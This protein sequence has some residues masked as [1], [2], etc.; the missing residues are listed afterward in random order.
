MAIF[1][2][3]HP[4]L[5][6]TLRFIFLHPFLT[7]LGCGFTTWLIGTINFMIRSKK[8]I[9]PPSP[10]FNVEDTPIEVLMTVTMW[11]PLSMMCLIM[12]VFIALSDS[13]KRNCFRGRA[14]KT[15]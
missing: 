5:F 13:I 7:W 4:Y 1:F 10:E 15:S 12:V 11:G 8:F 9:F 6:S 3:H 14:I 2:A